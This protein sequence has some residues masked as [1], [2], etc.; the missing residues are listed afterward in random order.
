MHGHCCD[1]GS[2]K[3]T[4]EYITHLSLSRTHKLEIEE[5]KNRAHTSR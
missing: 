4:H 1:V 5:D 2:S 3:V